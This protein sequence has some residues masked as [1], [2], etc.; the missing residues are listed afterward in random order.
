MAAP[1]ITLDQI[2][3]DLIA[4]QQALD[5]VLADAPPE[6]WSMP[7]D[8]PR[9]SVADQI[10]HLA[11]FDRAA[12][13]AIT[14][15]DRFEAEADEVRGTFTADGAMDDLTL[16]VY[17]A[18]T[19][20]Q[21]LQNWREARQTLADAA[22]T[23]GEGDRVLWYGPSMSARSFLTARLMECWAH[24]ADVVKALGAQRPATDR[25]K[26]IATL[27][28]LTRK[29][30]YVNR[31]LQPPAA[32]VR[33]ELTAPSGQRWEFG[34]ADAIDSVTGTAE[35]FCRV[36]TQ[37]THVDD[38]GLVVSG[39]AAREWLEIAQCFAGPATDGPASS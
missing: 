10:A 22:R 11:H 18:M 26:H 34:P 37:R 6:A 35:D 4:E 27:G 9:W 1:E 33:V 29:W 24:G 5:A 25:L 28:V 38:T 32:E 13:T 39:A 15:P 16:P 14:D 30:S 7:T 2:V 17:R 23:L 19:P 36:V 31:G 12:A 8:S 20:A 21:L 3:A